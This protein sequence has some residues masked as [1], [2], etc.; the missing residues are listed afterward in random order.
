MSSSRPTVSTTD[1]P[2]VLIV[3]FSPFHDERGFFV[4]TFNSRTFADAGLPDN[5]VQDNH[6]YSRKGVL[7]GLHFQRRKPQGKLVMAVRGA[8]FDVALDVR[9]G[10][11]TFGRWV[12]A[13]LTADAMNALWIP[14]GFAHGFC[15][16]TDEADVIYK[17]TAHYDH[18]DESGV[19]WNDA[20]VAIAWPVSNPI[21]SGKDQRL[22]PLSA[23]TDLPLYER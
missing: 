18:E 12:G 22:M 6:S 8:I 1:I 2:G 11:P 9:K 3:Q 4:E 15:T 5:F 16:L 21:V 17:C 23:L 20:E 14:P 13:T 10:S 7:R 19:V